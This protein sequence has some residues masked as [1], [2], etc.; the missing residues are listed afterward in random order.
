MAKLSGKREYR[1]LAQHLHKSPSVWL[2]RSYSRVRQCL[3]R[4][5]YQNQARGCFMDGNARKYA[6]LVLLLRVWNAQDSRETAGIGQAIEKGVRN[7]FYGMLI[8]DRALEIDPS[9]IGIQPRL[10]RFHC[11]ENRHPCLLTCWPMEYTQE[12]MVTNISPAY[13]C[14]D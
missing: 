8:K 12:A 11:F 10:A 4:G 1:M 13:S 6:L 7:S 9:E 2:R 14:L 3:A 5:M